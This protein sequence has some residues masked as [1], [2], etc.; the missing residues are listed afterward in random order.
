[1]AAEEALVARLSLEFD[2]QPVVATFT[3]PGGPVPH[4]SLQKLAQETSDTMIAVAGANEAK[5]GRR[6]SCSRGCA[7]CCRHLPPLA[8]SEA[9]HLAALVDA[10]P[11]PQRLRIR[12]RFD[13]A[14]QH[15]TDAGLME[16]LRQWSSLNGDELTALGLEYFRQQ[17]DCPFLE[18]E[19]CTI[20]ADRPMECREYLVTSPPANCRTLEPGTVRGVKLPAKVSRVLRQIDHEAYGA[21]SSSSWVPLI[22]ALEW[23]AA[24]PEEPPPRPGR[25]LVQSFVEML[26][27]QSVDRPSNASAA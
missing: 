10:M 13:R 15:A 27:K 2:G 20:H 9:H 21:S 5:A 3:V 11:E 18:D 7:A 12:E 26:L 17:I 1:M 24:H 23:A 4:R 19:A 14:M 8:L 6:I 25:A 22:L 16:R